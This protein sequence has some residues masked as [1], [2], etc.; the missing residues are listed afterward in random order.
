MT[1]LRQGPWGVA[2]LNRAIAKALAVAGLLTDHA[3]TTYP[4]KPILISQNDYELG[5][6]NGDL[7]LLLP[8]PGPG[9]RDRPAL[10]LVLR[11]GEQRPAA[12]PRPVARARDWRMP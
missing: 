12:R 11:P 10:R 7:G 1:P 8:D 2:G 9:W 6:Y 4:G 5:L 3:G